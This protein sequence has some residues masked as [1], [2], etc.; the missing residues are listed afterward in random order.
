M[1]PHSPRL[2]D[3]FHITAAEVLI[4]ATPVVLIPGDG[5]GPDVTAATRA[6]LTATGA[7]I[8]WIEAEAGLGAAERRGDPLPEVTLDLIR[9]HR[10]ALKGP[11]TTPI[12]KGF[13]SINVRLRQALDLRWTCSTRWARAMPPVASSLLSR[14]S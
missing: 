12:G 11:C 14:P 1:P 10:V 13:R 8:A 4:L 2:R 3:R 7:A 9:K 5:I 6:V